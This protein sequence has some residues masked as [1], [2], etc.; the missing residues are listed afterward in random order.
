VSVA[1]PSARR[2][3]I[4]RSIRWWCSARY[5]TSR[6]TLAVVSQRRSASRRRRVVAVNVAARRVGLRE[7]GV[8]GAGSECVSG[9]CDDARGGR[10]SS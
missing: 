3:A 2:A 7:I 1:L 4:S 10:G 5:V 9:S 6:G 8:S